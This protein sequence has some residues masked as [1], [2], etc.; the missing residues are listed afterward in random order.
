MSVVKM[1]ILHWI[2]GHTKRDRISID[3]VHDKF[4]GSTNSR[5]VGVVLNNFFDFIIS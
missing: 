5:E 4:K 2:C 3:D 1:W